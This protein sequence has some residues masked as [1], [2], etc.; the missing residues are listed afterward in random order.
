MV[1]CSRGT[2][3][4]H[5]NTA[6]PAWHGPVLSHIANACVN[7]SSVG[8]FGDM[9]PDCLQTL[10]TCRIKVHPGPEVARTAGSGRVGTSSWTGITESCLPLLRTACRYQNP[11]FIIKMCLP[12]PRAACCYRDLLFVSK[13]Y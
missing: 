1:L 3:Y 2:S 5:M 10:A 4:R 9:Q 11:L 8:T 7:N 6:A 13:I 12:L